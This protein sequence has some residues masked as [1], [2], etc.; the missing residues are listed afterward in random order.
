[1][2]KRRTMTMT[3]PSRSKKRNRRRGHKGSFEEGQG[4]AWGGRQGAGGGNQ[5]RSPGG[6]S[7][8]RVGGTA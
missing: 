1:M 5:L 6:S 8:A 3:P 4:P 7:D 2:K